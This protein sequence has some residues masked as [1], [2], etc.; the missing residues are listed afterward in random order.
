MWRG[1]GPRM[2]HAGRHATLVAA[3]PASVSGIGPADRLQG[4]MVGVMPCCIAKAA[5][6]EGWR[7]HGPRAERNETSR[8]LDG[9]TRAVSFAHGGGP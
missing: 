8:E 2:A 7:P 3:G 1:T 9:T 5:G 6:G 4:R